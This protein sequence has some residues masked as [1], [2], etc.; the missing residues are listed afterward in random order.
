MRVFFLFRSKRQT[1]VE[2]A[3]FYDNF[4]FFLL[5]AR[6]LQERSV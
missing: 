5:L 2:N 6:F 4:F 1:G 3:L